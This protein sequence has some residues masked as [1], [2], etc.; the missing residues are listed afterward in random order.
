MTD[1]WKQIWAMK[2]PHIAVYSLFL[3]LI[4][5]V[6][7]FKDRIAKRRKLADALRYPIL[8]VSF[9][10]VGLYLKSQP[11]VMNVVIFFNNLK[12]GSFPL[13]NLYMLDPFIF[14]SFIFI[15]LTMILWGRGGFC[16][17]LCPY[18]AMLELLN[19]AYRKLPFSRELNVPYRLH[20]K[21][22][23]L[24][25]A[26][27]F[28]ILGA[29]FLSFALAE[30]MSEVEPFKTFVLKLKRDW[31]FVAYFLFLTV[32]SVV[33]YRAFCRYLCPLGGAIALPSLIFPRWIPL[34]KI[35][36][37]E[38]CRKCVICAASCGPQ[39]I[40]RDGRIDRRECLLC[41][42]CHENFW[43][44]DLCP[45]LLRRKRGQRK[46]SGIVL[47]GLLL[48]VLSVEVF[49]AT[50]RVGEK[51]EF[52][53]IGEALRKAQP[54]D[55]ILVEGGVYRENLLIDKRVHL[56]GVGNP[57]L[58][59]EGTDN[60]V[61]FEG[62]GY[63]I[64][65]R[66]GGV[67]VEGFTLKHVRSGRKRAVGIIIERADG[68]IVRNNRMLDTSIGIR[69]INSNSVVI[70]NN[71]IEGERDLDVNQRGNCIDMTGSNRAVIV[72]N[73]LKFCKDGIYMEVSHEGRVENNTIEAS[74]Y[75]IHTMWVDRGVWRNNVTRGNL[76]GLAIMYTK[77]AVIEGN[78][79]VGN[80]T[81]GILL[82]QA[83]RSVIRN[84][85]VI[86]N[87][88]GI[89]FF[90]AYRNELTGNLV[91]NHLIGIWSLAASEKNRIEGNSFIN[92][93]VQVRFISTK[94]KEE[95]PGNY[96]SDYL[97]WDMNGDG[98]G[99]VPYE[100]G[101]YVDYVLWR[102]PMSKFLFTS[103]AL[104]TITFLEKQFPVF[105]TSKVVDP[106]PR[107]KPL[108]PQWEELAKK[109]RVEPSLYYS[110]LE[111]FQVIH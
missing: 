9:L 35:P 99:D 74:R 110:D 75:S 53:S 65:I 26:V 46:G 51:G 21:L 73:T 79:A 7:F 94:K 81:H 78:L 91:M 109:Y 45:V 48:L 55:T 20:W 49:G 14:L 2:A 82:I 80:T 10:Y 32:G 62:R 27:F 72:G 12:E 13:F 15:A 39:A 23:Y 11:T 44:E 68:V 34:R 88:C 31:Y 57:V 111:K 56:K 90:G 28:V 6:L 24:K 76:L 105:E 85:T 42:E 96:W 58:E 108:H 70:E 43:D 52:R 89:Y 54:G 64:G 77:R 4:L 98:V 66:S 22:V 40:K 86:G 25:Y 92:N 19:K 36:R 102:Y 95:W 67:V 30:Y 103:P 5:G 97:G 84:N 17:W 60:P 106:R 18:G 100:S 101:S 3:L 59:W 1:L 33:V 69:V 50:L 29:S 63:L 8:L 93:G 83:E 104:Q 71:Y 107:M 38:L 87:S 47:V 37:Y 16:G 61:L 41:L